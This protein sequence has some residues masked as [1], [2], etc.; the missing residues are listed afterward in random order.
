M[1]FEED[2]ERFQLADDIFLYSHDSARLYMAIKL[3]SAENLQFLFPEATTIGD[4]VLLWKSIIGK[5]F[6]SSYRD[7]LEASDKLRGWSID[8]SKHLQSDLHKL[9]LLVQRE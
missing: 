1:I 6:G 3:A 2:G 9:S 7:M 8:P 4:G 5:L